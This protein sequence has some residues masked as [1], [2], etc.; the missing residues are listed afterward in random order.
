MK[1][2]AYEHKNTNPENQT[3]EHEIYTHQQQPITTKIYTHHQNNATHRRNFKTNLRTTTY[4]DPQPIQTQA[5]KPIQPTVANPGDQK[6]QPTTS[7]PQW[8][9][10]TTENDKP[11]RV[12]GRLQTLSSP[13]SPSRSTIATV[14]F[15][16][17]HRLQALPL[18]LSS[19][20]SAVAFKLCHRV[21]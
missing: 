4:S 3:Q 10:A 19:S 12:K 1:S 11:R 2:N 5:S 13:S 9:K 15:K 17:C 21:R 6:P 20:S 16:H 18:S 14:E 7:E 8:A